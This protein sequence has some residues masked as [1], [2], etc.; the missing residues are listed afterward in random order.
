MDC[1]TKSN[2]GFSREFLHESP[3]D[4]AKC[5][6]DLLITSLGLR[7]QKGDLLLLAVLLV[8]AKLPSLFNL[9]IHRADC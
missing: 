2:C 1:L 3:A 7:L 8:S 9:Q 4:R 6:L 5:L